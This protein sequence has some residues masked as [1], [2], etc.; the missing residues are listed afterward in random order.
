MS[1]FGFCGPSYTSQSPNVSADRTMNWYHEQIESPNAKSPAS[2]YPTPGLVVFANLG[3][4]PVYALEYFIGRLFA[5][6]GSNLW[7]LFPDGSSVSRGTIPVPGGGF[8]STAPGGAAGA[9]QILIC[10]GGNAYVF[11][12]A[13]NTLTN[14]T[15][16][17]AKPS[18]DIAGFTDGYFIVHFANTDVF[19]TS[20]LEDATTWSGLDVNEVSVFPGHVTGMLVDHRELW[21]WGTRQSQVYYNSGA[22]N[23]PFT[24]IPGAFIEHG[25]A[26]VASPVKLDNSVFWLG[27]DERGQGM[28]WR[29]QGYMPARVSN[30]AVEYAWSK[31]PR[32]DD[33][34]SY[35]YQDQGHSF[36]V[37]YFPSIG[38][39]SLGT[40]ATW[41][42]DAATAQ[43]HERGYWNQQTDIVVGMGGTYSAHRSRCHAYAFGKHLV[44]DWASGNIYDMNLAYQDDIG[45]PIRR[46]RRAPHI[47]SEQEWIFHHQMQVDLEPALGMV[48]AGP[49]GYGMGPYGGIPYGAGNTLYRTPE[50]SLRW[51]DDAT[52]TWSNDHLASAGA[53]GEYR[54][55]VIWRRLGRS[56][57]RIY[58]LVATD[59][60]PYRVCDAYLLATPGFAP[61]ERL[62]KQMGKVA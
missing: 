62:S 55:R 18:P 30:H 8:V 12:L 7:E 32:I 19:Q 48:P 61:Q 17:L 29:A 28:A 50:I 38:D 52:K 57:D 49:S 46:L 47:S 36:W 20:A 54:T 21:L 42:F 39:P 45:N 41:V 4:V 35:A 3:A 5:I 13:T 22:A 56:R 23:N 6:S 58:E 51:S 11:A 10:A 25:L 37:L 40:G 60:V 59:A 2:L 31:Y 43:W 53:T 14:I 24:P 15:A 44:G 1:R 9:E 34:I 27:L 26:A 16:S 33:A